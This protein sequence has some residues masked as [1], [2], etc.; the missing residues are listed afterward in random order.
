MLRWTTALGLAMCLCVSGVSHA[1]TPTSG[2]YVLGVDD[3]IDI[4]VPNH[5]ELD[6]ELDRQLVILPDGKVSYP[7]VGEITAAGKTPRTL[8]AAIQHILERTRNNV[9]VVVSVREI[10][11]RHVR[12]VGAVKEGGSFDLKPG[13][14]LMDLVALSGGLADQP[15]HVT[16]RL[17]RA[18]G[19]VI[20]LDMP[21]AV[22][23][24]ESEANVALANDDLVILDQQDVHNQLHVLGQVV[25][26][27]AYDMTQGMT[28][29]TLLA[30][31]G[32]QTEHAALKQCTLVRGDKQIPLNLYPSLIEGRVDPAVA[33]LK[34]EPG[35]TL[36]VPQIQQLVGV[37][38]QV[39][40]PGYYPIPEKLTDATVLKMLGVAGGQ[41]PEAD[42]KRCGIVRIVNGKAL[43]IPLDIQGMLKNGKLAQNVT[44]LPEDILYIPS[45]QSK[46][47][48]LE[49]AS[50]LQALGLF[51]LRIF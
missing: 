40:K 39:L 14:H 7:E 2:E 45:R 17:V 43:V 46:K 35:D 16:G 30:E 6:K 4:T 36:F 44:L 3:V 37:M 20:T 50:P 25:K 47:S 34:V 15:F 19:S 51:G 21:T 32:S 38:G 24:P 1:D 18:G 12:I 10:H 11:S 9:Q 8:A 22:A 31:A 5:S 23:H 48:L 49:F 27:G 33:S 26:P 29:L 42:L 41:L 13:W 28:V